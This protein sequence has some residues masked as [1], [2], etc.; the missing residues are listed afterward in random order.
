MPVLLR[1]AQTSLLRRGARVPLRYRDEIAGVI[2]ISEWFSIPPKWTR[3]IFGTDDDAHPGVAAFRSAPR[4]AIAGKVEWLARGFDGLTPEQTRNEI[5]IGR[6]SC[7]E[8][9]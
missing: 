6:A 1:S 4:T 2:T 5:E 3:Q 7:R 9:V 8:R